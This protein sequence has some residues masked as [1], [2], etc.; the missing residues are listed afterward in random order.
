VNCLTITPDTADDATCAPALAPAMNPTQAL[1]RPAELRKL[2]VMVKD[3]DVCFIAVSVPS[4][5]RPPRGHAQ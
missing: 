3:E 1:Y 5:V 4:G 2:A